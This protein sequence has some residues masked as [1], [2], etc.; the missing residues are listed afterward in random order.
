MMGRSVIPRYSAAPKKESPQI[1][2]K[3]T[4]F[5]VFINKTQICFSHYAHPVKKGDAYLF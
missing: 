5:I 3:I 1:V 4:I 2:P